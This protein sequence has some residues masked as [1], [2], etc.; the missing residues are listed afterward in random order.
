[1]DFMLKYGKRPPKFNPKTL[2]MSKYVLADAPPPPPEKRAWEYVIADDAWEMLGN[3]TVGDCVIAA[4]M[5][6]IMASTAN[7]GKPATF[8]TELA[9]ELYSAI[10]GYDPSQTDDEG[11][12]PTDQ[13]T[14]WTDALAYWQSTGIVDAA[15]TIHKIEAW[16]SVGLDLPSLRQGINLF[17]GILIG[18]NVTNSMEQQFGNGLPWNA[19]FGGGIAGGHGI[20]GFGYGGQGESIVTWGKRQQGD[21]TLPGQFDEAYAVVTSDWLSVAGLS[22]SGLD[23]AALQADIAGLAA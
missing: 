1:M 11:N 16:G 15:G 19:P 8:T 4:M 13:G 7:T 17:G 12:N 9:L 14:T 21:L 22:P 20:P 2:L 10:T 5:H 3:D 18:L 23:L 6:F